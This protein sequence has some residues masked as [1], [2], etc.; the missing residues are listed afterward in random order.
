M[1]GGLTFWIALFLR[2]TKHPDPST[3]VTRPI[4]VVRLNTV[5]WR[6]VVCLRIGSLA[7][8]TL[9]EINSRVFGITALNDASST[10]NL[11]I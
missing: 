3:A 7:F 8:L 6:D 4:P 5:S 9:I 10:A 2:W 1:A 11:S